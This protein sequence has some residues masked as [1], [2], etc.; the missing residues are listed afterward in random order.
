MGTSKAYI[1]LP[2]SKEWDK[3][4]CAVRQGLLRRDRADWGPRGAGLR[5][6]AGSDAELVV[7]DQWGRHDRSQA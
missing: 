4:Q 3:C 2:D 1:P 6:G 5:A 7:L